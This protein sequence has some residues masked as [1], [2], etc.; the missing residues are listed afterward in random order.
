MA[1]C[2]NVNG[3]FGDARSRYGNR[4]QLLRDATLKWP[5]LGLSCRQG[6]RKPMLTRERTSM[7]R[8]RLGGRCGYDVIFLAGLTIRLNAPVGDADIARRGTV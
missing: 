1:T 7:S 6:A 5:S 2:A 8:R 4:H 3:P